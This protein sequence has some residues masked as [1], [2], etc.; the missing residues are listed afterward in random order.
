MIKTI[1]FNLNGLLIDNNKH[2]KPGALDLLTFL[3]MHHFKIVLAS[4]DTRED[5]CSI[6]HSNQIDPFFDTIVFLDEVKRNKP[7][8]DIYIRACQKVNELPVNC[9]VLED[10]DLGVR[11]GYAARC[12]VIC[13]PHNQASI[14]P[15]QSMT[16]GIL[17]SLTE[18]LSFLRHLYHFSLA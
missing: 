3:S 8:P 5:A 16:I 1:I 6:L 15:C 17:D 7:H 12:P 2:L 4:S 18:V 9:L 13:I 11:A 10:T 14:T